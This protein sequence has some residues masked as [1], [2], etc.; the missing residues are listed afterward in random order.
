MVF[1]EIK[2][3]AQEVAAHVVL[4]SREGGGGGGGEASD[5]GRWGINKIY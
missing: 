2:L 1:Q 5:I 3:N 4:K